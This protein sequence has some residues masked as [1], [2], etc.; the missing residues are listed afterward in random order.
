MSHR[1]VRPFRAFAVQGRV[2]LSPSVD[3][4]S[5]RAGLVLLAAFLVACVVVSVAAQW[6]VMP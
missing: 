4:A 6:S 3:D 5:E 2:E 1:T